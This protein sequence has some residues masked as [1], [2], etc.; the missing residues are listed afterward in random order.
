MPGTYDAEYVALTQLHADALVT[1]DRQL[2][3]AVKDP[4]T[5]APIEALY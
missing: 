4:V 1:P 3:G 2:A 5:L